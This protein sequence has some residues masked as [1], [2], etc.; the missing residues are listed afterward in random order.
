MSSSDVVNFQKTLLQL[1]SYLASPITEDR[2]RAG[3][4]QAFEFTFEQSWKAIQKTAGR[5]GSQVG[6]PK[7]AYTIAIQSG[8]IDRKEEDR[9]IRLLEDRNLTSHTYKEDLAKEVLQRIQNQYV[10]MFESLLK[11]LTNV[12]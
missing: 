1:K 3:I 11:R 12:N 2:D 6:N 10:Q 7:Q 8:W 4:I 5:M 9:W